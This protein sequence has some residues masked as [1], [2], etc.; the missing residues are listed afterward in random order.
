MEKRRY[1]ILLTNDDGINSPGLWAAAEALSRLGYVTVAAPRDNSTSMGRSMPPASDGKLTSVQMRIGEQDW[2]VYAVGGTPAQAVFHAVE[3]LLP[4]KPDLV[5]SGINY[6]ENVGS[7]ITI[8]GTVMAALEAAAAGIPALAVSAQLL[9]NTFFDYSNL[10]FSGAAYFTE[11]FARKLLESREQGSPVAGEQDVAVLKV[12]VP[13]Q[14]TP[15]TPWRI[16]RQSLHRYYRASVDP[17]GSFEE[18]ASIKVRVDVKP[19]ET[20]EDTDVHTLLFDHVVSV[21]P[22]SLDMTA[23]VDLSQFEKRLRGL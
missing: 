10:D 16:T 13:F 9:E 12:D 15:D 23:R 2:S 22:I 1:Q 18:N 8:S 20:P 17:R 11:F 7:G 19:G 5:V 14:A 6:G 3:E 4:Q 21:T